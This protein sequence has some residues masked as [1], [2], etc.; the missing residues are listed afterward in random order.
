AFRERQP[1]IL[2]GKR[3]PV[4]VF[5]VLGLREG[6]PRAI[7]RER[8]PLVGRDD[9]L[10]FLRAQ[11]RRVVRDERAAVVLVTGEAGMGKSRLLEELCSEISDEAA[12]AHTRYPAYGGMGGPQVAKEIA[13]Q[14][15]PLGE[16]EID[17][18]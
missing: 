18:R 3:D 8:P 17:V 7:E 10:A 9:D 1:V 5:E 16:H 2:K 6:Q 12:V 15:G 4:P 13:E 11:W 14:L